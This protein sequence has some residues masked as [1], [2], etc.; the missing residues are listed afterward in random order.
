MLSEPTGPLI[1]AHRG[2]SAYAPENTLA[3]FKLALEQGADG[4]ELDA[5]LSADGEIVVIHD[6][7]VDRTTPGKGRV[8][9]LTLA[10]L[11]RLEAGRWKG[12]AFSGEKIPTLA[13]VF[14]TVGGKLKINVEL[15]NYATPE[16]GLP[17]KALALVRDF[18]LEDSVL[19]SSFLLSNLAAVRQVWPEAPVGIL[20]HPGIKGLRNRSK[21][22]REISPDY[23]HPYFLD[24]SQQLVTREKDAGRVLNVWTVNSRGAM[25]TLIRFGVAGI[26][27]DDPLLGL[28]IRG[29]R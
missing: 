10:E 21:F 22:S 20:T 2:A 13:E 27:T 26:I 23:L 28:K 7:T 11:K 9:Q 5:K 12:E 14:A 25:R 4:I 3:A 15:T 6:Q 8:N 1:F 29:E 19:F 18:H 17:E 24:V 16:D